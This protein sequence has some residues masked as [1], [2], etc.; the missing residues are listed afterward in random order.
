MDTLQHASRVSA[1]RRELN[2]HEKSGTEIQPTCE[3][4]EQ[5]N[6]L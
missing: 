6:E 2:S 3:R 5:S 4:A 1:Y